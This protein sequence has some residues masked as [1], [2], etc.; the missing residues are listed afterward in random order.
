MVPRAVNPLYTG[1]KELGV[2]LARAFSFND[3]AP[4]EKQRIFVITG[5]GGT[6]KSEICLKYAEDHREK[7][8]TQCLL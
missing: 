3:P 5:L 7:F 8:V 6:G 4:P 2:R 1:R